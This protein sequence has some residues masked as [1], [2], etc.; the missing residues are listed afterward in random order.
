MSWAVALLA[1]AI[2]VIADVTIDINVGITVDSRPFFCRTFVESPSNGS[3]I[4]RPTVFVPWCPT[5]Y[6]PYCPAYY[7]TNVPCPCVLCP[8]ILSSS[9]LMFYIL[10]S[11]ALL[12]CPTTVQLS[13]DLCPAFVRRL[14]VVIHCRHRTIFSNRTLCQNLV[15]K[16]LY[17]YKIVG[18]G[19]TPCPRTMKVL[20]LIQSQ[21]MSYKVTHNLLNQYLWVHNLHNDIIKPLQRH[22]HQIQLLLEIQVQVTLHQQCIRVHL[23]GLINR[24]H[25]LLHLLSHHQCIYRCKSWLLHPYT[26]WRSIVDLKELRSSAELLQRNGVTRGKPPPSPI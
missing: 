24:V 22:L 10:T 20:L 13:S 15:V 17:Y 25:L 12:F 3:S 5:P 14:S 19:T 4:L 1:S 18:H 8:T 16:V 23:E 9:I 2:D 11:Y 21:G 26:P 6:Y 7:H